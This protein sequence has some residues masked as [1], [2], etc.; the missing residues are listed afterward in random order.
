MAHRPRYT[1]CVARMIST[2]PVFLLDLCLFTLATSS[3]ASGFSFPCNLRVHL[4]SCSSS[5]SAS[6][7]A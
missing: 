7:A 5:V 6:S 1:L 4:P 2:Q 3:I